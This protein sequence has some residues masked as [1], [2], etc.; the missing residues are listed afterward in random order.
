MNQTSNGWTQN[1]S[2]FGTGTRGCPPGAASP[3]PATLH[4]SVA[5]H[6]EPEGKKPEHRSLFFKGC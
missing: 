4:H 5:L 2:P 1:C 3:A 6:R